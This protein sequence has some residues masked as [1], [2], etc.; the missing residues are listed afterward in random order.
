MKQATINN[1]PQSLRTAFLQINPDSSRLLAM[2]NKD[3]ERMLQ[4]KDWKDETISSIKVPALIICGDRDV[5]TSDHAVAMSKLISNSRLMILPA[6][7]GSYI[8]VVESQVHDI[9]M[10][11]IMLDVINNFLMG[12]EAF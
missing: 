4:F 12:N 10:L 6:T 1:M 11:E 8:G 3:K 2:F 7:H 9:K 5:V